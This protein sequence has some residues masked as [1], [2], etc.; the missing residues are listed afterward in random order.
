MNVSFVEVKLNAKAK[1]DIK[2]N[3]NADYQIYLAAANHGTNVAKKHEKEG[4]L[5]AMAYYVKCYD[6]FVN[7]QYKEKNKKNVKTLTIEDSQILYPEKISV[8]HPSE[9]EEEEITIL[10]LSNKLTLAEKISYKAIEFFD[11]SKFWYE[12]IKCL[13]SEE[14]SENLKIKWKQFFE[15]LKLSEIE[16]DTDNRSFKKAFR[17]IQEQ[18]LRTLK[19]IKQ[20]NISLKINVEKTSFIN[21]TEEI[22]GE[23]AR[24][25]SKLYDRA[26][27]IRNYA[28]DK[29]VEI[30]EK[31]FHFCLARALYRET[32]E[33]VNRV[34][35]NNDLSEIDRLDIVVKCWYNILYCKKKIGLLEATLNESSDFIYFLN[36]HICEAKGELKRNLIKNKANVYNHNGEILFRYRFKHTYSSQSLV[37]AFLEY[38]IALKLRRDGDYAFNILEVIAYLLS[39]K[40]NFSTIEF[41]EL[42]LLKISERQNVFSKLMEKTKKES[43]KKILYHEMEFFNKIKNEITCIN[44]NL[45]VLASDIFKKYYNSKLFQDWFIISPEDSKK[46][47]AAKIKDKSKILEVFPYINEWDKKLNKTQIKQTVYKI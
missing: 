40:D 5:K 13:E 44:F 25:K 9:K 38:F 39:L 19:K 37:E 8:D 18:Y 42:A 6:N 28:D 34:S 33:E 27:K 35:E 41:I 20:S 43:R 7:R 4:D 17:K 10:L 29:C 31:T 21:I 14:M 36:L 15:E 32:I 47:K 16:Y 11:E 12:N 23:T 22:I 2:S 45:E 30:V 1:F 24:K 26:S 46:E 3:P